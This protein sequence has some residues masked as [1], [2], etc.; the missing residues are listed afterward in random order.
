MKRCGHTA[1]KSA[2]AGAEST[3]YVA[4]IGRSA[5]ASAPEN[6]PRSLH[7]AL[8]RAALDSRQWTGPKKTNVH[9]SHDRVQP[10]LLT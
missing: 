5:I 2:P 8:V 3:F 4:I 10:H 1:S 7:R 9:F 6:R